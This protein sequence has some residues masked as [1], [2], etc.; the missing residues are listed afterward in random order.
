MESRARAVKDMLRPRRVQNIRHADQ[1]VGVGR[2]APRRLIAAAG[3]L[4]LLV[5]CVAL[6]RLDRLER[7]P[8]PRT[9]RDPGLAR[10]L[11]ARP[12]VL[13]SLSSRWK[14]SPRP[15]RG[16]STLH[17]FTLPPSTRCPLSHS[18]SFFSPVSILMSSASRR[19][20]SFTHLRR[21]GR[22]PPCRPPRGCH[23]RRVTSPAGASSAD[24]LPACP[25]LSVGP[26]PSSRITPPGESYARARIGH[27][28]APA[29][30]SPP[31]SASSRCP[32]PSPAPRRSLLPSRASRPHPALTHLCR[33]ATSPFPRSLHPSH[34]SSRAPAPSERHRLARGRHR[35]ASPPPSCLLSAIHTSRS[36]H[37]PRLVGARR[38][39]GSPASL[40]TRT[41]LAPSRSRPRL[42]PPPPPSLSPAPPLSPTSSPA[43]AYLAIP[44][45]LPR[46]PHH[47]HVPHLS[48]PLSSSDLYRALLLEPHLRTPRTPYRRTAIRLGQPCSTCLS[49]R[50][51]FPSPLR[52]PP[53][54]LAP[55]LS[56]PSDALAGTQYFGAADYLRRILV[57]YA[58]ACSSALS[59]SS[60]AS[61][62]RSRA[63]LARRLRV[64]LALL[65]PAIWRISTSSPSK[66]AFASIYAFIPTMLS[67]RRSRAIPR[68]RRP[69]A[70]SAPAATSHLPT[71]EPALHLTHEL[72]GA[73]YASS[74]PR[75]TH[76]C[77][78][79]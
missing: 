44:I 51:E 60:S 8:V 12:E 28:L 76:P 25:Y 70:P 6:V 71:R 52:D 20:P 39:H 37:A 69:P 40:R 59:A 42:A 74:S 65:Y 67:C 36:A 9:E 43:H 33:T 63:A 72:G 19:S 16:P 46:P 78:D 38:P 32:S 57:S 49:S 27:R 54:L 23:G 5:L 75:T 22:L 11:L 10:R 73:L 47:R 21:A 48:R 68:S 45:L 31:L 17:R 26:P 41:A 55:L 14:R 3:V 53:A 34:R 30:P 58:I 64:P 61:P 56:E 77:L 35:A 62:S 7:E 1:A 66:I 24:L 2:W 79:F 4:G 50:F 13:T 29:P 15:D 18:F